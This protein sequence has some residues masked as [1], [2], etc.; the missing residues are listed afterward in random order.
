MKLGYNGLS[1]SYQVIFYLAK[2]I[3]LE[4]IKIKPYEF[5]ISIYKTY[6]QNILCVHSFIYEQT[7]ADRQF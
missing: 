7:G 6:L 2:K 5:F 4:G 3:L 1:L